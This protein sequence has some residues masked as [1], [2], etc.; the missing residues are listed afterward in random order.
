MTGYRMVEFLSNILST[1]PFM[2]HGM[3]FM[4]EPGVLWLHVISDLLI[5]AAYYAIPVLLFRFSRRRRD[6][7][8]NWIFVAFGVFI[9]ACGS[10]ASMVGASLM[11]LT[12]P[13]SRALVAD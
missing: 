13:E 2:P 5:A 1:S 12:A 11:E 10:T 8:F 9:L 7:G 4:W 6:V 3:C